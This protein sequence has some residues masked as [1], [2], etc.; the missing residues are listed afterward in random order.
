MW[1]VLTLHYLLAVVS[2]Q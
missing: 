1:S 2:M